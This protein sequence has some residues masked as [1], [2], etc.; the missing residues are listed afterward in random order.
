MW[1]LTNLVFVAVG[2]VAF[3]GIG[4]VLDWLHNKWFDSGHPCECDGKS[5]L[6]EKVRRHCPRH[7]RVST[8]R[9]DRINMMMLAIVFVATSVATLELYH[10][11]HWGR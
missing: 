11:L 9:F 1:I 10:Y 7:N 2:T 4:C 8:R 3:V 6:D 5:W